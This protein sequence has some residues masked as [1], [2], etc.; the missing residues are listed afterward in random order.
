MTEILILGEIVFMLKQN[1]RS[2][3]ISQGTV[4]WHKLLIYGL[5]SKSIWAWKY[6]FFSFHDRHHNSLKLDNLIEK[7]LE[8]KVTRLPHN[9]HG[10]HL[11]ILY[12]ELRGTFAWWLFLIVVFINFDEL[13]NVS[14]DH[15]GYGLNKW[16]IMSNCNIISCWST[17]VTAFKIENVMYKCNAISYLECFAVLMILNLSISNW[18]RWEPHALNFS[19]FGE[20]LNA[21]V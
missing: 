9:L 3:Y 15:S 2:N 17:M 1:P 12:L 18:S 10:V 20:C 8:S 14:K 11:A 6:L 13:W 5:I 21:A 7:L 19:C 4:G 16:E